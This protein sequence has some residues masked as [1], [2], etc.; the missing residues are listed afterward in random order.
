MRAPHLAAFRLAVADVGVSLT[1]R[2]HRAAV[3]AAVAAA[4]SCGGMG[5]LGILVTGGFWEDDLGSCWPRYEEPCA[6]PGPLAR[7]PSAVVTPLLP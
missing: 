5:L 7:C 3:A 4:A 1:A 2:S 6:G